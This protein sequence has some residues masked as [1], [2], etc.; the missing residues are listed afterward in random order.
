MVTTMRRARRRRVPTV[1]LASVRVKLVAVTGERSKMRAPA[2]RQPPRVRASH[3]TGSSVALSRCAVQRDTGK[4]VRPPTVR[5]GTIAAS[6]PHLPALLIACEMGGLLGCLRHEQR[7]SSVKPTLHIEASQ[8]GRRVSTRLDARPE[9][10]AVQ[11][12]GP[13]RH[14]VRQTWPGVIRQPAAAAA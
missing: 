4:P 10:H 11:R 6:S 9:R 13:V 8:Q 7:R 3:D 1:R 2:A 5:C 12:A 14:R